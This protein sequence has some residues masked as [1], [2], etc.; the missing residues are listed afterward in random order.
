M[1]ISVQP[2]ASSTA[3]PLD[4][5]ALAFDASIELFFLKLNT[6][7]EMYSWTY[8][9]ACVSVVFFGD[10]DDLTTEAIADS[11]TVI[12][13]AIQTATERETDIIGRLGQH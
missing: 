6:T 8:S 10:R 9:N 11:I 12:D 4:G 2:I 1:K 5:V 13:R 3:A 7:F